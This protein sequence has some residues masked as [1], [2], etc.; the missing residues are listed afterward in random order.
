[1]AEKINNKKKGTLA[2]LYPEIAVQWHPTRNGEL[3]PDNV[4]YGSMR[5]VWWKCDKGHEYQAGVLARTGLDSGCPYCA[6]RRAISGV[7]D[8]ATICP[9]IE[10]IW[11]TAKNG[12]LKPEQCMPRSFKRVWLVCEKGHSY[13]VRIY[14]YVVKNHRCPYCSGHKLLK[15]FNDLETRFPDVAK[16][17]HPTKNG[18]LKPDQVTSGACRKVW[19]MCPRGHEYE[20]LICGRTT[21]SAYQNNGNGC[22]YCSGRKV[23]KGYND[24]ATVCPELASEWHSTLNGNVTPEDVHYGSRKKYWWQCKQ[25]HCWYAEVHSRSR[26]NGT[27]CPICARDIRVQKTI[28][29]KLE[30][31]QARYAAIQEEAEEKAGVRIKST[32]DRS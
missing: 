14:D 2:S 29:T 4:T 8:L 7:N 21:A 11:D 23:L 15:G 22:P 27:N 10:K 26:K 25:G 6:G 13:D 30:K 20:A 24:L 19:W 16:E 17:W 12:D 28:K 18:D 5:K 31:R 1:M 3:T 9:E 32:G